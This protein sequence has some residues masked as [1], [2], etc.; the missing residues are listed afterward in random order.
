MR[1]VFLFQDLV[2]LNIFS[3]IFRSRN[4]FLHF[5][6]ANTDDQGDPVQASAGSENEVE[7]ELYDR[8][9]IDIYYNLGL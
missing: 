4:N 5:T 8:T 3:N 6:T 9:L 1:T 2:L 7:E